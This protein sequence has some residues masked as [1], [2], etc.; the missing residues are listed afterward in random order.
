MHKIRVFLVI[1]VTFFLLFIIGCESDVIVEE[2]EANC[3]VSGSIEPKI[4]NADVE[5]YGGQFTYNTKTDDNG[6]FELSDVKS[7][8]YELRIETESSGKVNEEIFLDK[9]EN[10]YLGT[11][12]LIDLPYPFTNIKVMDIN[13]FQENSSFFELKTSEELDLESL[14]NGIDIEPAVENFSIEE[15]N[16]YSSYRYE[17]EALLHPN[18]EYTVYLDSTITTINGDAIKEPYTE[19][20]IS[21]PISC[22]YSWHNSELSLNFNTFISLS[23]L[24]NNISVNFPEVDLIVRESFNSYMVNFYPGLPCG[25]ETTITI[26]STLT[27]LNGIMLSENIELSKQIDSLFIADYSP[28]NFDFPLEPHE[29]LTFVF[30]GQLNYETAVNA[31]TVNLY[32]GNSNPEVDIELDFS[33]NSNS[34]SQSLRISP[35]EG[36]WTE[37]AEYHLSISRDLQDFMDCPLNKAFETDFFIME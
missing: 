37:G 18:T 34:N 33:T 5:L 16:H 7:G 14:V 22:D 10:N 23:T 35:S 11:L 3:F 21:K 27:D 26:D 30:T 12:L 25:K 1:I 36:N 8:N 9:G 6:Y 32:D 15:V 2:T 20:F 29:R 4:G 28:S 19:T 24:S 17:L 13:D 31:I